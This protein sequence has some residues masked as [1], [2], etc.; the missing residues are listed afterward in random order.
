MFS[1]LKVAFTHSHE[2][3]YFHHIRHGCG[4]ARRQDHWERRK[5]E[6]NRNYLCTEEQSKTLNNAIVIGDGDP[7]RLQEDTQLT[8]CPLC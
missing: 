6:E 3:T 7:S 5:R 4:N 1:K 8:R 2:N